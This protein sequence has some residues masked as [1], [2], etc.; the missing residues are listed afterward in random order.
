MTSRKRGKIFRVA[1]IDTFSDES[2]K[3]KHYYVQK[4]VKNR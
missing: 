2:I 1:Q 3:K 4:G